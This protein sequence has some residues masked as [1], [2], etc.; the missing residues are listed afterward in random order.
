MIDG[1]LQA[2]L[3]PLSHIDFSWLALNVHF[4]SKM[5]KKK[6]LDQQQKAEDVQSNDKFTFYIAKI[7]SSTVF[8]QEVSPVLCSCSIRSVVLFGQRRF[9]SLI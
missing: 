3:L 8:L 5:V 2:N 9:T 6:V 7:L 1:S 4:T